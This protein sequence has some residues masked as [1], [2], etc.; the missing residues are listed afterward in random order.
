MSYFLS[1]QS[2]IRT[3]LLSKEPSAQP[4]AETTTFHYTPLLVKRQPTMHRGFCQI[5]KFFEMQMHRQLQ[6]NQL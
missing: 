6:Q 5:S 2:I 4:P 3:I 1:C